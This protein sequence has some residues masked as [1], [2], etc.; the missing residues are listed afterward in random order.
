MSYPLPNFH[1]Q[2]EWEGK[3]TSC[4]KVRNL[5]M[6]VNLIE[7][8]RGDSP[9]LHNELQVGKPVYENF[10]LERPVRRQDNE[11]YE[12]WDS[13]KSF[14]EGGEIGAVFRRTMVISLLSDQHEPILRWTIINA[15]PIRLSYSD[16]DAMGNSV[17]VETLEIA[18]EGIHV[19]NK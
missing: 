17:L 13:T 1:F 2:V 9:A 7:S 14:N 12:W 10:F 5:A 18:C 6:H 15:I 4:S 3:S 19:E 16:L 8:A 11:F